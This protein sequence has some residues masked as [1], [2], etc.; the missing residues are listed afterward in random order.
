MSEK[1]QARMIAGGMSAL[2][3]VLVFLLV[4]GLLSFAARL[5]GLQGPAGMHD[6]RVR[7]P[8]HTS[9]VAV[10]TGAPGRSLLTTARLDPGRPERHRVGNSRPTTPA[11][12]ID[13]TG[14]PP[15]TEPV[16]VSATVQVDAGPV[17]DGL[18]VS[19]G[20]SSGEVSTTTVQA[21]G[22][23]VSVSVGTDPI[24]AMTEKV[25]GALDCPIGC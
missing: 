12:P 13:P 18:S 19:A 15:A 25:A 22:A 23:E 7:L 2:L 24:G 3:A 14:T 11:D 6:G 9:N 21:A 17:Q 4:A 5:F 1:A 8:E 10:L 20:H 16:L